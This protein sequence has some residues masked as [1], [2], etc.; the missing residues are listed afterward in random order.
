M[1]KAK[2]LGWTGWKDTWSAFSETFD[3]LAAEK[4]LPPFPN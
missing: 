1:N 2:S 4:M 3:E